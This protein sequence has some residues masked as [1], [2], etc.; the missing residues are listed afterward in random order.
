MGTLVLVLVVD[1]VGEWVLVFVEVVEIVGVGER[2]IRGSLERVGVAVVVPVL[3]LE[4]VLVEVPVEVPVR[5]RV[6]VEVLVPVE[7]P[8]EVPV[9]VLVL[10]AV[11]VVEG[12]AGEA[13]AVSVL[14]LVVET[15]ELGSIVT[16]TEPRTACLVKLSILLGTELPTAEIKKKGVPIGTARSA[17]VSP[18][19]IR[20]VN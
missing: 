13:E 2:E 19:S 9:F 11:L 16:A 14:V 20:R 12:A 17:R 7:V 1:A 3:V 5:V 4:A 8:V 15:G 10:V 6:P 18:V